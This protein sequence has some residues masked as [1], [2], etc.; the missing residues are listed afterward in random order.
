MATNTTSRITMAP[1]RPV[2]D[3]KGIIGG[4]QVGVIAGLPGCYS[5]EYQAYRAFTGLP[6]DIS[7]TTKEIF[8][9]GHIL[10]EPIA[11]WFETKLNDAKIECHLT[12]PQYMY[13]DPD[14]PELILH[15]DRE[16][17]ETIEGKRYALECK[18][19]SLYSMNGMKW[20]EPVPLAH[21]ERPGWF[22]ED[23]PLYDGSSL[24]VGYYAQCLW[25]YALAGYD[26]VFLCRLTDNQ[27]FVY[28]V[29]YDE[30]QVKWLYET[31][32]AWLDKV[33]NGYVPAAKSED[34]IKVK[35]PFGIKEKSFEA[36]EALAK[37]IADYATLDEQ[38]KELDKEL[39][40][41]KASIQEQIGDATF[42]LFNGEK[43]C[44]W[45]NCT[46][47]GIDEDL[48]KASH[49]DVYNEVFNPEKTKYRQLKVSKPKAKKA[50]KAAAND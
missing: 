5:S 37:E 32:L 36:T 11:K 6:I 22:P 39:K 45:S 29:K 47:S 7:D 31:V 16:F 23:I 33:R 13:T 40:A 25:Y 15:P 49:P 8:L 42:V 50:D 17:V 27:F 1:L 24:N 2:D 35:Y 3:R 43:L 4:S 41:K 28:Y 21:E 44:S 46:R 26:G 19:A 12:E 34:D 9:A 20:P 48:L 10:E 14:H 18:T 38:C 30:K